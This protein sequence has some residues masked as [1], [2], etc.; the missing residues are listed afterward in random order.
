MSILVIG[1]SHIAKQS[2]KE[3]GESFVRIKPE[4]VAVELDRQRLHGLLTPLLIP[5]IRLIF[6]ARR[7]GLP[8]PHPLLSY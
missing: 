5:E 3:I 6:R 1:T 4:I 8:R 2:I 7:Q